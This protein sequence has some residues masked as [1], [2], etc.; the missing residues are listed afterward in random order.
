MLYPLGPPADIPTLGFIGSFIV[1]KVLDVGLGCACFT[2]TMT[3]PR[4][5]RSFAAPWPMP[6]R[7]SK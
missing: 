3:V 4:I 5:G 7:P 6:N 2:A 1:M